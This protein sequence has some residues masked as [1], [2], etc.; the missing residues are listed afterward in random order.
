MI[1][2]PDT[3]VIREAAVRALGEDRGPADITTLACVKFDTQARAR[4]FA[5]EACTLAGIPVA[6]QVFR[7][8]DPELVLTATEQDGTVLEPGDTVM[9]LSG[10]AASILTGERC[11]L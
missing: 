10:S 7:A 8:Q 5:K 4:I 2:L 3:A 6:E 9:E 1:P 11:A